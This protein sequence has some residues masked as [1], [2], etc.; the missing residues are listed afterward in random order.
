MRIGILGGT[1]PAGRGLAVRAALAGHDV[2][3]GSR[4][5]Q[6]AQET[7]QMILDA[8]QGATL[9]IEGGDNEAATNADLIVLATPWEGAVSTIKA[10]SGQLE[11]KSVVSMVNALMKEGREMLPLYPP[12]GSMAGQ[13]AAALPGSEVAAAFHHLPAKEMENLDSGLEADVLVCGDSVRAKET[14]I[15][16]IN[17]MAGLR[18]LDAGSLAQASPIEA[19]TA[20]CI[21]L[22]IRHKAHS[23]LRLAGI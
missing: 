3:L 22:N 19:F 15:E 1:G 20:V 18:G 4:D 7:A 10:L 12:R 2:I 14:T 21:T 16:L 8:N 17:S 23:T 6:R 13:V 9:S 5:A 11:G